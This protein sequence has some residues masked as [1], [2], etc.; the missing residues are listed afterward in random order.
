MVVFSLSPLTNLW[1][2][3]VCHWMSR[4]AAILCIVDITFMVWICIRHSRS[5][6]TRNRWVWNR[7]VPQLSEAN[8]FVFF[9]FRNMGCHFLGNFMDC[10][11]FYFLTG[12]NEPGTPVGF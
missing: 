10:V 9:T 12:V 1:S 5:P 7:R 4:Y 6:N 2:E 8:L 11:W 3:P